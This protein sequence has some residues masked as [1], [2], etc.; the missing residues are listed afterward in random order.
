MKALTKVSALACLLVLSTAHHETRFLS[1]SESEYE[2][3]YRN[4][5]E[6]KHWWHHFVHHIDHDVHHA[7][8]DVKHVAHTA[9]HDVEKVGS[10]I[11]KG[12]SDFARLV[13]EVFGD[14]WEF[15]KAV[16]NTAAASVSLV[17]HITPDDVLDF[18]K[19][20]M[21]GGAR[22]WGLGSLNPDKC[23][24]SAALYEKD[25]G[26]LIIAGVEFKLGTALK[27]VSV[28]LNQAMIELLQ[29]AQLG[30]NFMTFLTKLSEVWSLVFD[31]LLALGTITKHVIQHLGSLKSH[32]SQAVHDFD[33]KDF[34][35]VGENWA[36]FV[37]IVTFG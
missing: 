3:H 12:L 17:D 33:R 15:I 34:F 37:S 27:Q 35:G 28:V 2:N 14:I 24:K 7:V 6:N 21:V 11:E 22:A 19:G 29:C 23:I 18:V 13:G 36:D 20:L 31:P 25:V 9:V 32:L 1:Q 26:E 30:T 10:A 16:R 5:A 8:H 4:L